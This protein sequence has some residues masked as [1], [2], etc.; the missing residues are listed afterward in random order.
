MNKLKV[1]KKIIISLFLLITAVLLFYVYLIYITSNYDYFPSG[2]TRSPEEIAEQ[3]DRYINQSEESEISHPLG[4][5]MSEL[6]DK[7]PYSGEYFTLVYDESEPFFYY[8]IDP[9]NIKRGNEEF[10]QFLID[11]GFTKREYFTGLFESDTPL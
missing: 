9:N 6:I 2:P 10:D 11:N 4:D 7:V 5:E 1:N 3:Y 8:Y